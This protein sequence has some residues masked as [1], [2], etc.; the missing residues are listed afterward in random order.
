MAGTLLSFKRCYDFNGEEVVLERDKD[1]ENFWANVRIEF[2]FSGLDCVESNAY[3]TI[4]NGMEWVEIDDLNIC[5]EI[6]DSISYE[7]KN[8]DDR[9]PI[10]DEIKEELVKILKGSPF[11]EDETYSE[12]TVDVEYIEK[13]IMSKYMDR[14]IDEAFKTA[15]FVKRRANV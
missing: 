2:T 5:V 6:D 13:E 9:I 7:C 11:L 14:L 3:E 1:A 15:K 10:Y 4:D 8:I 12:E